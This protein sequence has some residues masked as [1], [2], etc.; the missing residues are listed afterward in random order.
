MDLF[1]HG[2]PEEF[3]LI[4]RTFNMTLAETRT[5]DMDAKI[6]YLHTLVYVEALNHFDLLFA[7]LKNT[8]TINVA[9]YIKGLA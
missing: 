1:D 9:Y 6:Q 4:I 7:D 3:L 8:E 2:D 5:L